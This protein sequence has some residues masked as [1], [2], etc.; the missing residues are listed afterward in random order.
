MARLLFE[1]TDEEHEKLGFL[2]QRPWQNSI[3]II[4]EQEDGP[5]EIFARLQDALD[6]AAPHLPNCKP[7]GMPGHLHCMAMIRVVP[8]DFA[9][10]SILA[11]SLHQRLRASVGRFDISHSGADHFVVTLK[12]PYDPAKVIPISPPDGTVALPAFA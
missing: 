9:M 6:I 8:V 7:G 4:L 3:E 2:V 1:I 11:K 12:L 5:D 10:K